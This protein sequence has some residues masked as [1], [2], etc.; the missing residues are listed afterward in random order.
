ML[1]LR[2]ILLSRWALL[3]QQAQQATLKFLLD[4][5]LGPLVADPRPLL[6][7]QVGAAGWQAAGEL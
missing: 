7:T 6:R 1:A 5:A 3:G 2:E 4:L